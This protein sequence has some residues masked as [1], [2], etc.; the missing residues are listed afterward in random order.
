MLRRFIAEL[1]SGIAAS[2]NKIWEVPLIVAE[3]AKD[4]TYNFAR[5]KYINNSFHGTTFNSSPSA[6]IDEKKLPN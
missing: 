6:C 4:M 2:M 3:E 5:R 1:Y